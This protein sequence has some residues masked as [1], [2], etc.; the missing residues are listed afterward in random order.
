MFT[1]GLAA[2]ATAAAIANG[3]QDATTAYD[4]RRHY[5]LWRCFEHVFQRALP[6]V[7][8]LIVAGARRI[9]S[10]AK[11]SCFKLENSPLAVLPAYSWRPLT[12]SSAASYRRGLLYCW[13]VVSLHI[14]CGGFL[15]NIPNALACRGSYSITVRT[16]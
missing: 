2:A 14:D 8:S 1:D 10:S 4:L 12:R 6:C 13:L 9:T 3:F 16:A 5:K 7:S 15:E 11:V